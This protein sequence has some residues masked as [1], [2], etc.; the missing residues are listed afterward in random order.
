MKILTAATVLAAALALPSFARADIVSPATMRT[1][2][3][4]NA[5]AA[6]SQTGASGHKHRTKHAAAK[7]ASSTKHRRH[8][9]TSSN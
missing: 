4:D 8:R 3:Q 2:S 7:S 1:T 9:K 5:G 6:Q